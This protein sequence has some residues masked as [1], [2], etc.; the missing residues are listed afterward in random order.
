MD[1]MHDDHDHDHDHDH[2]QPGSSGFDPLKAQCAC[3][4]AGEGAD[5]EEDARVIEADPAARSLSRA[6]STSFLLLKV[7][8]A[9]LVGL[10]LLECVTFIEQGEVGLKRRFGD[11]LRNDFGAV[12][13]Y[14]AGELVFVWPGPI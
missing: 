5:P 1:P 13:E 14:P 7:V 2:A 11:Y 3:S 9:A 8:M 4:K 6:L 10:F 12:R